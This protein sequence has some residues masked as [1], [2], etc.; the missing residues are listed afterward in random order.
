MFE[1][2]NFVDYLIN[3][4]LAIIMFGIGLSLTVKEFRN[5]FAYPKS[6][7]TALTVQLFIIPVIAF[8]VAWFSPITPEART[9]IVLVS[10][11]ASGASSNLLTHLFRG[12]VALA[13]SMT[14]IN[15]FIT[16]F[17]IPLISTLALNIFLGINRS[18]ELPVLETIIQIFVVTI[19]PAALGVYFRK[20][21]EDF[22]LKLEKHLRYILVILLGMVFSVKI[23]FAEGSGGTGIELKDA[24]A[25]LPPLLILNVLAML[26]GLIVG[27]PLK[28]PF[29]DRFTISI[30]VGLH[31]TAL[32]LLIAGTIIKSP[33]MEKPAIV[34]AA[35]SFFTAALFVYVVK[36]FGKKNPG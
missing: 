18:I 26:T 6:L 30:E 7:L 11:C 1:N 21:K 15:S 8:I 19:I 2:Y 16:L 12:N 27:M 10:L 17:S 24:L 3:I 32:A 22:A 5:I 13:I 20:L 35:F 36:K 29:A 9:G 34:Y 4:V 23:F 28:I 33:E 14:T 31:N 25:V